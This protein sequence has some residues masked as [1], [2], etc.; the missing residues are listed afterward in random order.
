[1][2][3][4]PYLFCLW[5]HV[6]IHLNQHESQ[7]V[8]YLAKATCRGIDQQVLKGQERW[9]FLISDDVAGCL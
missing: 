6:S 1:M 8:Q 9:G 4:S 2:H 7:R 3:F 5:Y